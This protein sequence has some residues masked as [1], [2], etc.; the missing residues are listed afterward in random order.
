MLASFQ[1][2]ECINYNNER[3]SKSYVGLLDSSSVFDKVWDDGLFVKVLHNMGIKGKL[4]KML[5]EN[6]QGMESTVVLNGNV[7]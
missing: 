6:Y 1:V 5:F 7:S 4:W 2:Q 3:K